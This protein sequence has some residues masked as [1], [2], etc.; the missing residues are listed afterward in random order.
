MPWWVIFFGG[1][2]I[3]LIAGTVVVFDAL[4]R[5]NGRYQSAWSQGWDEGYDSAKKNYSDWNL[6]WN[7]GYDSGVEAAMTVLGK[8]AKEM[9]DKTEP[10][11]AENKTS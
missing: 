5:P 3:G 9:K 10:T 4:Y 11:K 7:Q 1:I 2:V 6:G 8:Y